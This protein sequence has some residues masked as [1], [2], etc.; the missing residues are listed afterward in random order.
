[1]RR[2]GMRGGAR[3]L[4]AGAVA[5]A[6]GLGGVSAATN[7][8][9]A[10]TSWGAALAGSAQVPSNPSTGSGFA[11]LSLAGN[12][13]TVN[14]QWTGL[15]GGPAQ[16]AHIHCCVLPTDNATVAV[17]FVGFPVMTAGTYNATFDLANASVYT[18]A[19][20]TAN[21]GSAAG[22]ESALLA[23]LNAGRAYVNIHNAVYPGGEIRGNLAPALTM[24][25]PSGVALVA[26]GLGGVAAIARRRRRA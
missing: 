24:P 7:V 9:T 16:A 17:P 19:F 10:Q 2:I 13:L 14:V 1:M 5:T 4:R 25:E 11:V 6:V 20:L 12:L 8:A 15:T 21:G 23:G 22:A 18:S 3:V 26:A